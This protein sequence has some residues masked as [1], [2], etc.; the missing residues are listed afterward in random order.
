MEKQL[1]EQFDE[2]ASLQAQL[3]EAE[4]KAELSSNQVT[5][6]LSRERQLLHECRALQREVDKLRLELTKVVTRLFHT[7]TPFLYCHVLCPIYSHSTPLHHSM[8]NGSLTGLLGS[9]SEHLGHFADGHTLFDLQQSLRST[10]TELG[11]ADTLQ[12]SKRHGKR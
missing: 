8:P 2:Q 10:R 7:F 5:S 4:A 9:N 12:T 6:L 3:A 1:Q 11:L